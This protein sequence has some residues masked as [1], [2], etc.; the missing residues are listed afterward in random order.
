MT[1]KYQPLFGQQFTNKAQNRDSN[2]LHRQETD[3]RSLTGR[4]RI[5]LVVSSQADSTLVEIADDRGMSVPGYLKFLL[6]REL[7]L[8]VKLARKH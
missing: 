8:E 1:T 6:N 7:D 4:R 3:E 5:Q 2:S